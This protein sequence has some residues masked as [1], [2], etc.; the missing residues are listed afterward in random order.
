MDLTTKYIECYKRFCTYLI[1]NNIVD[2][3]EDVLFL[4]LQNDLRESLGKNKMNK[5]NKN[6]CNAIIKSGQRKGEECG[7]P[8][9]TVIGESCFCKTHSKKEK[10][11]ERTTKVVIEDEED[12]LIIKKNKYNNF[13][14]GN[15]G[16]IFKSSLDKCIVAKEGMNGEW[17]PLDEYDIEMCKEY[18]LRWKKIENKIRGET[19]NI[20][21][22]KKYDLFPTKEEVKKDSNKREFKYVDL[23]DDFNEN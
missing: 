20:D 6:F 9:S 7:K 3:D 10:V 14:Y 19:T 17:L 11:E 12:I 21:L 18:N 2:V 13:V 22:I 8:A 4:L 1:A 16:L 5:F 15:T 23:E